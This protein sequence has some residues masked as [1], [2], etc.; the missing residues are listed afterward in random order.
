MTLG[1]AGVSALAD[2]EDQAISGL[3]DVLQVGPIASQPKDAPDS[4]QIE[5]LGDLVILG[6]RSRR[7]LD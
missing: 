2:A 6:Q 4:A 7:D 1:R 3:I 5:S